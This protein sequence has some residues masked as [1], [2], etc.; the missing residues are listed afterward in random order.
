ML[1]A[2]VQANEVWEVTFANFAHQTKMM[3]IFFPIFGACPFFFLFLLS[4]DW[5]F[6]MKLRNGIQG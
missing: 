4:V 3:L 1:E 5:I 6:L 2:G